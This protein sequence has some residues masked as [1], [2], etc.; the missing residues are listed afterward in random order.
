MPTITLPHDDWQPRPDQLPMWQAMLSPAV[1]TVVEV[2]HRRWGKD[3]LALHWAAVHGHQRT[4][5][6]WHALPQYAQCRKAIWEA[7]NPRT[8]RRRIFDAFPQPL[9]EHID[10]QAMRVRFKCGSQYQLVGS[11]QTDGLVGTNP[12][13]IVYSEAALADPRAFGM[14]KPILAENNGKQ[15]FISTPRGRNHFY[16]I[17]NTY[18]NRADAFTQILP[19]TDTPVFTADQLAAERREYIALYG[20]ALGASMYEQ[21]YLTSFEAAVVGAVFGKELAEL[22]QEGRIGIY[23]Y[24]SRFPVD[25]A[26]DWGVRDKTV[27]LFFQRVGTEIRLIDFYENSDSALDHYAT[28]LSRKP[29][30]YGA[31]IAGHDTVQRGKWTAVSGIEEARRLGIKLTP[32]PNTPMDVRIRVASQLIKRMVIHSPSILNDTRL[33]T[34]LGDY[35]VQQDCAPVFQDL[36]LYRFRFDETRRVMSATPIHDHTSHVSSALKDYALYIQGNTATAGSRTPALQ[37]LHDGTPPRLA[38][39]HRRTGPRRRGAW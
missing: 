34:D 33:E 7:I 31:F 5:T 11:D 27:M 10:E 3:E 35:G 30:Y 1:R 17:Y 19:A 25:V 12:V 18:K 23:R 24:D 39:I 21:E 26:F 15:I 9:I 32:M 13:A 14:F 36:E 28:V 8:G 22:K 38:D 20:E 37:G 4:G 16:D 6:I 29:Y 2:A